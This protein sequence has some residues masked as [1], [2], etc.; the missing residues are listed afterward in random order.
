MTAA[1]SVYYAFKTLDRGESLIST[2]AFPNLALFFVGVT[3]F[4]FHLT[5]KYDAQIMDD[6]SMFWVCAAI[7]YELYTIGRSTNVKV[8][9]GSALTAILGY[10]SARHYTLNQLWLHNWTFIILVTAIWPRVLFL[11]RN[12]LNGP[13]RMVARR[14]FRVGGL[15]FLAGFLL[16]LVDG[17]YCGPLRAARE[18]LGLPWAFLLEFHG[19][20]HILTSIGAG[21]CIRV[22]KVLTGKTPAVS[23]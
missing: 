5:M 20:W 15:C 1:Q 9:F 7:I 12:S 6:L 2:T 17:A 3:S 10:I 4:A 8:V 14:Q 23:R 11:I 18:T 13:E 21:N 16:W 22:T 19:W